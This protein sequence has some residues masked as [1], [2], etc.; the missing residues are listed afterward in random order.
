MQQEEPEMQEQRPGMQEQRPETLAIR[1]VTEGKNTNANTAVDKA[2]V[3]FIFIYAEQYETIAENDLVRSMS[4]MKT[5]LDDVRFGTT[6]RP[7]QGLQ[8]LRTFVGDLLDVYDSA[9]VTWPPAPR[10]RVEIPDPIFR[11]TFPPP[12][13]C[14]QIPRLEQLVAML[15]RV[16]EVGCKRN[17]KAYRWHAD[18]RLAMAMSKHERLGSGSRLA[19]L[20]QETLRLIADLSLE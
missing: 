13:P 10:A 17:M 14:L 20:E 12:P 3:Q 7:L 6:A 8:P 2:A 5:I 19:E 15:D 18:M 9:L 11:L 16:H 4:I 1:L